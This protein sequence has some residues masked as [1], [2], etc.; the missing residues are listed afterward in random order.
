MLKQTTIFRQLPLSNKAIPK[1]SLQTIPIVPFVLQI[2]AA[3]G[4]TG[5]L[6]FPNGQK[7]IKDLANRLSNE[8]SGRI[9]SPSHQQPANYLSFHRD[10]RRKL[11]DRPHSR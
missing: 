1:L 5:Y 8:V 4:L 7:A 11:C 3:L 6:S 2:F 9:T 10:D